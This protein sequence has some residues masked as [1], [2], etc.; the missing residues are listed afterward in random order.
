[1]SEGEN[2]LQTY[3]AF[4]LFLGS[5]WLKANPRYSDNTLLSKRDPVTYMEQRPSWEA[6]SCSAGRE[7]PPLSRN[8]KVYYRDHKSPQM[9]SFIFFR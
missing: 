9:V 8:A 4:R 7:I 5:C 1:M 6:D 3:I 2:F